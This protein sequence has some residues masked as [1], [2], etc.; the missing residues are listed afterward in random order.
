MRSLLNNNTTIH[1]N[2]TNLIRKVN[3][4]NRV[5]N[6]GERMSSL[7]EEGLKPAAQLAKAPRT[8]VRSRFLTGLGRLSREFIPGGIKQV[9]RTFEVRCTLTE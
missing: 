4:E 8:E 2:C 6:R 7:E 5:K 1:I 9:Q 3:D